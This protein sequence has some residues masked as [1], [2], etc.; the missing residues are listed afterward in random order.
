[1][2]LLIVNSSLCGN[3]VV[4]SKQHQNYLHAGTGPG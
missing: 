4:A 2:I 3:I 1:M